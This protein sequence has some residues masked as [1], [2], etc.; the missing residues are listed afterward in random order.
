MS[1]ILLWSLATFEDHGGGSQVEGP[2]PALYCEF[3]DGPLQR[4]PREPLNEN[5]SNGPDLPFNIG[6]TEDCS[7]PEPDPGPEGRSVP[8]TS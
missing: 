8:R 1:R 3:G 5:P 7:G 6:S 4:I 2:L